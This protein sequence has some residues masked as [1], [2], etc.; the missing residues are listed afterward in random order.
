MTINTRK[1]GV[2]II[3]Q[4]K[5]PFKG[6]VTRK[7]EEGKTCFRDISHNTKPPPYECFSG[8]FYDQFIK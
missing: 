3:K 1:R 6:F 5:N 8:C 7:I 4:V 2:V